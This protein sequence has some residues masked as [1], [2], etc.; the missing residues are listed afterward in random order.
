MLVPASLPGPPQASWI[1]TATAEDAT[2]V[3][4]LA[5]SIQYC[6][7]GLE[8][9]IPISR[10]GSRLFRV[11]IQPSIHAFAQF[12]IPNQLNALIAQC[13]LVWCPSGG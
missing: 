8:Q 11:S 7:S 13:E 5:E 6:S 12:F 3:M 9:Q 4:H 10:L 1:E 2:C